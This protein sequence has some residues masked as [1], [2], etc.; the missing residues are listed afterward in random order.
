ME[1]ERETTGKHG[2][3]VKVTHDG[4]VYV[5]YPQSRDHAHRSFCRRA[6][7]CKIV[8]LHKVLWEERHGPVPDGHRLVFI[9][10]NQ[11]NCTL[12]NLELVT[13]AEA[14]ARARVKAAQWHRSEAAKDHHHA[15][16]KRSAELMPA[17][18]ATC[19]RCGKSFT[20]RTWGRPRL[21]CSR[22]CYDLDHP[23]PARRWKSDPRSCAVC[24]K[25][26]EP[27]WPGT[28]T[29]SSECANVKRNAA[30]RATWEKKRAKADDRLPS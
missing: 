30:I 26:F 14:M 13:V 9:D 7:G 4:V 3:I 15:V 2:P 10:G 28:A 29:C 16:G 1:L 17:Y 12:E 5:R 27:K 25:V 18:T 19:K 8:Y 22:R 11:G 23:R 21:H 20:G 6:K 24:G